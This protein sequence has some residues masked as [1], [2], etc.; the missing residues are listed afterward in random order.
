MFL[1]CC[2]KDFLYSIAQSKLIWICYYLQGKNGSR[3]NSSKN[4]T[5]CS[6]N[7]KTIVEDKNNFEQTDLALP[8]TNHQEEYF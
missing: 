3:I 1:E 2:I 8:V 5:A 6:S 4:R 7:G